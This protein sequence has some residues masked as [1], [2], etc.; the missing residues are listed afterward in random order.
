MF[1]P[2]RL[3]R[4]FFDSQEVAGS[5]IDEAQPG[6][7]CALDNF[8][9]VVRNILV[10][11]QPMLDIPACVRAFENECRHKRFIA[12][13]DRHLGYFNPTTI[14]E[15]TEERDFPRMDIV[16]AKGR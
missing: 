6:A 9:F 10:V 8:I 5:S 13:R 11:V 1:R 14:S 12:V 4:F 15:R 2:G 3:P 16:F 7:G